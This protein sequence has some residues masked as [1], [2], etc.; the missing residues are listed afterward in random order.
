MASGVFLAY[1]GHARQ[2]TLNV[3]RTLVPSLTRATQTIPVERNDD[4]RYDSIALVDLRFGRPFS[5]GG[6][7]LEPF[8][9]VYNLGNANT[10]VADVTTLGTSLGR[11]SGTINPRIVKF[12]A[13]LQF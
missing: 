12:G 1:S 6:M 2:R 9:D 5:L 4:Q 7:T 13:K 8:A 10:I 11:V 3:S